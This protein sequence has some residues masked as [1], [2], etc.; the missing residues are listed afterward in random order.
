MG[1]VQVKTSSGNRYTGQVIAVDPDH[2]LAL[3]RLNGQ[4]QFP[5]IALADTSGIQVG[6]KVYAIGSP[7]GLSGTFTTGILSRISP[8]GVL[9]TDAAINP[10]NSGGP[11]LNSR[12]EL[13]GVN[14]AI[15]SPGQGGNI[16]IGF[17]TSSLIAQE[18]I[19][20]NQNNTDLIAADP[21]PTG[22]RLGISVDAETLIIQAVDPG[23][24]ANQLGLRPGDRLVAVNGQRLESIEPLLNYLDTRPDRMVLTVGRNQSVANLYIDF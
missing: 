14:T 5:T 7:F 11:L 4:E 24:L 10:G 8:E 22:T 6:Q 9:Q 18:F 17:A 3:V 23:S 1:R 21:Q 12:G 16:G 19:A 2:D 15:L 13:I 20:R